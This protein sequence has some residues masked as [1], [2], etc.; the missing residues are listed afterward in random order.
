MF[1]INTSIEGKMVEHIRK[2]TSPKEAWN[3]LAK[4]FAKKNELMSL[5]QGSLLVRDYFMKVKFM[6]QEIFEWEV[7]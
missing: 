6:C 7:D 4:C 5:T 3:T 2:A 1:A